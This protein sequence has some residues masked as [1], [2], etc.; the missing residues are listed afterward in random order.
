MLE[1]V[2]QRHHHDDHVD[3]RQARGVQSGHREQ[4]C[5]TDER[6]ELRH[7]DEAA[8]VDGVGDRARVQRQAQL[9]HEAHEP[10]Q[11]EAQGVVR[12]RVD[13]PRERRREH[14]R[15]PRGRGETPGEVDE[16][17]ALSQRS[18]RIMTSSLGHACLGR[19]ECL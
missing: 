9:R 8:T 7:D 17:W 15:T 11:A 18:H 16:E 10:H 12:E 5:C 13:L 3:Q 1:L 6:R 2:R 4:R 19:C 14:V